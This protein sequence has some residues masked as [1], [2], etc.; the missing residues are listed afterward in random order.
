M[1]FWL[2]KG[3]QKLITGFKIYIYNKLNTWFGYYK[4]VQS[5]YSTV[6]NGTWFPLALK[7][8]IF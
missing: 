2:Y 6:R 5:N 7:V 3:D 4:M 1:I 8:K